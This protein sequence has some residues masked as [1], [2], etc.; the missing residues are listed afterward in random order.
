MCLPPKVEPSIKKRV[1]FDI[2]ITQP[3]EP[4]K[5][6]IKKTIQ[7]EKRLETNP[8]TQCFLLNEYKSNI[9]KLAYELNEAKKELSDV[10]ASEQLLSNQIAL[11]YKLN[12]SLHEDKKKLEDTLSSAEYGHGIEITSYDDFCEKYYDENCR[13]DDVPLYIMRYFVDGEWHIWEPNTHSI[14]I[15]RNYITRSEQRQSIYKR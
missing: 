10:V 2:T 5:K 1:S 14:D 8:F 15:Y 3:Q 11:L 13:V 12:S 9:S 6:T 7:E 4:V